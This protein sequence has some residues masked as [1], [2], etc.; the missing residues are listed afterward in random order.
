MEKQLAIH[1][2]KEG[3]TIAIISGNKLKRG[4]RDGDWFL[5]DR[6]NLDNHHLF[7]SHNKLKYSSTYG[8]YGYEKVYYTIEI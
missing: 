1:L 5:M 6:H 2:K 7:I 3:M 8:S 4:T